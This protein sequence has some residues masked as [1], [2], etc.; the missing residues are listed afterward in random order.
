MMEM[1][2][3]VNF[4]T[5]RLITYTFLRLGL[6]ETLCYPVPDEKKHEIHEAHVTNIRNK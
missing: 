1:I 3:F 5:G 4:F 2:K 6:E